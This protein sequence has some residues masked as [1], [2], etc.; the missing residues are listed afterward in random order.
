MVAYTGHVDNTKGVKKF[1]ATGS[2]SS[3]P[4][5][6][7]LDKFLKGG[8]DIYTAAKKFPQSP[9]PSSSSSSGGGWLSR[10]TG[11]KSGADDGAKEAQTADEEA[12][13]AGIKVHG[14]QQEI[15]GQTQTAT[16]NVNNLGQQAGAAAQQGAQL[17][18]DV[19]DLVAQRD[20]LIS[21]SADST[22]PF[23]AQ[24][25]GTGAGK[26][27]AYSLD[28]G[29]A[30]Q[31]TPDTASSEK[32]GARPQLADTTDGSAPAPTTAP[33]AA[34]A[35][36]TQGSGNSENQAKI[37]QLNSQIETKTGAQTQ[38]SQTAKDK[39]QETLQ[40]YQKQYGLL[41][42]N[43]AALSQQAANASDKIAA[44]QQGQQKA[45]VYSAIGGATTAA[46]SAITTFCP[47][48][49]APLVALGTATTISSQVYN[50]K[51]MSAMNSANDEKAAVSSAQANLMK[52]NQGLMN[53][54]AKAIV[55]SEKTI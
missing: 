40:A 15:Q 54:Y 12:K 49:G 2:D 39:S 3:T 45:Q 36:A 35:A 18:Q 23:G 4:Y 33:T 41:K 26:D 24:N 30:P 17:G 8:G 11:A 38:S 5:M 10:C 6:S 47:T 44:A 32:S 16:N 48:V 52:Q 46:G 51:E 20:A 7:E 9:Q 25:D 1:G 55:K 43:S 21:D 27:S 19:Q 37:E 22:N 42:A 31:A 13:A 50:I 34:P 53:A 14:K 29:S 28:F